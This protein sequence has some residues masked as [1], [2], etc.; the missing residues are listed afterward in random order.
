MPQV[1][2]EFHMSRGHHRGAN[3]TKTPTNRDRKLDAHEM[4]CIS[5]GGCPDG[6]QQGHTEAQPT[7]K[8]VLGGL[9]ELTSKQ[10]WAGM[11]A[12]GPPSAPDV[13]RLLSPA[14]LGR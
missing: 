7:G 5:S 12:R 6:K 9:L 2:T 3:G 14:F 10:L 4:R 1:P 13:S 11:S 8:R